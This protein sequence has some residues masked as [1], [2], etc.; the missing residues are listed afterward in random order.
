MAEKGGEKMPEFNDWGDLEKF[1]KTDG[2]KYAEGTVTTTCP[3]CNKEQEFKVKNEQGIG[4]ICGHKVP[5]K[6]EIK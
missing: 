5:I 6:F 2:A 1:L 3:I 4:V